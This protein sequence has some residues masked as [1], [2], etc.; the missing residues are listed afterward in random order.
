MKGPDSIFQKQ[1]KKF[2]TNLLVLVVLGVGG[3]WSARLG[4]KI[5]ALCFLPLIFVYCGYM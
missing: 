3:V 5:F 2:Y 4:Y 1:Y